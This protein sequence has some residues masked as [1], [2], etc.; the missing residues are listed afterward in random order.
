MPEVMVL[1]CPV[2]GAPLT[3][4]SDRCEFCGSV[5]FIRSDAPILN[6]TDLNHAVIQE[7]IVRFRKRV[8]ADQYDEEAHYGL[9]VAYFNLGLLDDAIAELTQAAR[10]MPEN[11]DIQVQ[12]AVVLRAS[13]RSGNTEA[14]EQMQARLKQA[15]MLKPDHFE[16]NMLMVDEMIGEGNYTDAVETLQRMMTTD[17]TRAK[18]KL[19]STLESLGTQRLAL[20]DWRGVAWCW[21]TLKPLNA[22]V[23]KDLAVRFLNQH[24]ELLPKHVTTGGREADRPTRSRGMGRR[25]AMT[26]VTALGGLV[27]GTTL[28]LVI[29]T[30]VSTG[31]DTV[32]GWRALVLILAFLVFVTS[33]FIAAVW[34]WRRSKARPVVDAAPSASPVRVSRTD[35][36]AGNADA[37][38]VYRATTDVM[39]KLQIS[40]ASS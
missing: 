21:Q 3:P 26:I 27:V 31:E 22:T 4:A 19:I 37:P 28:F 2:C 39:A 8:R 12:L 16:G 23:A 18:P 40:G 7:N 13:F 35:L 20:G 10:L 17:A 5:I 1:S 15:L 36:L 38:A 30:S 11:P 25:I 34:Y 33:P 29:G 6:P 9:G 24:R 32:G 14:E